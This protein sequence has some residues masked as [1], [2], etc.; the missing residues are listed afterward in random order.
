MD[1][2]G[3]RMQV[4]GHIGAL[5]LTPEIAGPYQ[6]G[7]QGVVDFVAQYAVAAL[8][9]RKLERVLVY[10]G[11]GVCLGEVLPPPPKVPF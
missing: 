6:R 1:W 9:Q 5:T 11:A 2:T 7:E 4:S 8:K 3:T 10:D